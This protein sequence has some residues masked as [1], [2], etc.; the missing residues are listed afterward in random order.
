MSMMIRTAATQRTIF[1]YAQ[2]HCK[3]RRS[4]MLNLITLWILVTW[5]LS[6][7]HCLIS[8]ITGANGYIA[9]AVVHELLARDAADHT[10][11]CLV[12][13]QRVESEQEYWDGQHA[14]NIRVLP[15]DML[16]GGAS[17]EQALL[18]TGNDNKCIFHIASVFGPTDNHKQTALNN[19]QGTEDL[20]RSLSKVGKCKLVLTSSMA[21]VRGT[22][23]QPANGKCYTAVDWNTVSELGVNWGSS[24]QWSKAESERR[25]WE[26]CRECN[27][28]MVSLC[29]SFV[30]GPPSGSSSSFSLTLVRQW[31][32]GESPVQS[33]LF[34]DVRDV[35][36][37]HVEA[38]LRETAVGNR[39]IISTEARVPS[40]VI[41]AWLRA[42][43][44]RTH[45]S[46]PKKIYYDAE[47]VGGSIPIGAQ[48][49]EA[50]ARLHDEL[51]VSL[52]PVK[53]TI[54]DMAKILLEEQI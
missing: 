51:G 12:R 5:L 36:K 6:P 50:I 30:F 26:L 49:V 20:V 53:D 17:L 43:C 42:V 22:G 39:Y 37:A 32:R 34:V 10:I 47:F 11:V 33:R 1:D 15:Y 8:I 40:Q 16:D 2:A 54:D 25:A 38:A 14:S 48:E 28:P 7:A 18:S 13:P 41:A 46:H 3:H 24:Y 45:L 52:R 31:T 44:R 4:L 27:V 35:A 19:V 29:P 21:A 9:R 23:Q